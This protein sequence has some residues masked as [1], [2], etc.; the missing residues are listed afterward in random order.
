VWDHFHYKVAGKGKGN[1]DK[2]IGN[3]DRNRSSDKNVRRF[4]HLEDMLPPHQYKVYNYFML[5]NI[6][7]SVLGILIFLFLFWKRLKEDYAGE[8]IF[9]FAA[10][11]LAGCGIGFLISLKFFPNWFFWATLTGGSAGLAITLFRFKIKFYETLEAFIISSLPWLALVFLENSVESSSL[12]SFLGFLAI[13]LLTFISY[14]FDTHYKKFS[15]YRSGRIGFAGLATAGLFFLTRFVLAI[16]K[17]PVLSLVGTNEIV[18]A[19][20]LTI[21]SFVLLLSLGRK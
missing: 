3:S 17:V 12:S 20:I 5:V 6:L 7:V 11:I 19:G 10:Y 15:L 2:R 4:K 21:T 16:F 1:G 14:Y 8:V 18:I 13:L 9:E